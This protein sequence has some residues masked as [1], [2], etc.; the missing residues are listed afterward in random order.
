EAHPEIRFRLTGIVLEAP[1]DGADYRLRVSGRLALAGAER[2]VSLPVQAHRRA[3]GTYRASGHLPLVM[4]DFGI[5]PPTA[6]L[7]LVRAHDRITVRFD[8][9][10]AA[11]TPVFAH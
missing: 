7:G 4:S 11:R 6:V 10:A 3:D 8:L 5:D 2:S 9:V 1:A